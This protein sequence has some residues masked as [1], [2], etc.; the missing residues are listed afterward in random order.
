MPTIP[1]TIA[2]TISDVELSALVAEHCAGWIREYVFNDFKSG[3]EFQAWVNPEGETSVV[4]CPSFATDANAVLKLAEQHGAWTADRDQ[5][6]PENIRFR[7]MLRRTMHTAE[8]STLA[9]AFCFC[10]LKA[11]GWKVSETNA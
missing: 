8:A 2:A 7:V 11:E 1:G 4:P 9:R 10:L 6:V 5:Y 3:K